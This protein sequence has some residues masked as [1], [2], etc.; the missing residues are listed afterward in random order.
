MLGLAIEMSWVPIRGG[1]ALER[2][3]T[4]GPSTR[5]DRPLRPRDSTCVAQQIV[6]IV[7]F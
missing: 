2:D 7:G 3:A 4:N 6:V 5:K 1:L